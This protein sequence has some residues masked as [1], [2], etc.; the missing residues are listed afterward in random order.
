MSFK[1]EHIELF[2]NYLSEELSLKERQEFESRLVSDQVFHDEFKE[3]QAFI[4]DIEASFDKE[5]IENIKQ[6]EIK[7][8]RKKLLTG[9][10]IFLV[11]I[12]IISL[13]ISFSKK[14][15]EKPIENHPKILVDSISTISIPLDSLKDK[16]TLVVD[17]TSTNFILPKV[18]VESPKIQ[19]KK[20]SNINNIKTDSSYLVDVIEFKKYEQME[21]FILE[22][23]LVIHSPEKITKVISFLRDKKEYLSILGIVYEKKEHRY[24]PST[25]PK[26]MDGI[27]RSSGKGKKVSFEV[28]YYDKDTKGTLNSSSIDSTKMINHRLY[29]F[30]DHYLLKNELPEFTKT[31][32]GTTTQQFFT[33]EDLM[34]LENNN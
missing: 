21:I 19:K 6:G 16:D 31:F 4:Y 26:V 17:S 15:P 10:S 13:L 27:A 1:E 28:F 22:Q 20:T 30:G 18:A 32:S 12:L 34:N 3:Y 14:T 5:L 29:K 8:Q 24:I 25:S 2:D 23:N 33:V 11:L 7:F 9:L